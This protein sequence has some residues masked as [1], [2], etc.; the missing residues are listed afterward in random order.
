MQSLP[1]EIHVGM[2]VYDSRHKHIGKIDDFKFSENADLEG[3]QPADVDGTDKRGRESLI[4]NIAEA[5]VGDELPK[6]LR[7]RLLTE[8]YVRLE[9]DGLFAAD[10]YILPDQI[11]SASSDELTLKVAKEQ[12]IKTH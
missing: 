2:K 4:D 3:T 11:A 12:L 9:A 7:D 6:V 10:R 8:G 5:F 1:R